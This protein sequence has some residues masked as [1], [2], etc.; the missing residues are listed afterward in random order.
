MGDEHD[1]S[2][3][4]LMGNP[5]GVQ[6]PFDWSELQ[7]QRHAPK[8]P[9]GNLC[10]PK[11]V[12]MG[13]RARCLPTMGH[14]HESLLGVLGY[15]LRYLGSQPEPRPC[16]GVPIVIPDSALWG[17]FEALSRGQPSNPRSVLGSGP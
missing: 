16:T 3:E 17:R 2:I 12:R 13:P 8:A 15:A 5:S 9:V 7:V 11:P 14:H 1:V 10:G 6:A 4:L